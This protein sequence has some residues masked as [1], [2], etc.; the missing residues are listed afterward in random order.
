MAKKRKVVP[1]EGFDL[2]DIES[3]LQVAIPTNPLDRIIGQEEAV[4]IAKIAAT[5]RRHLLLVGPP[6]IGK[7]MTA[8]AL[9]FY[10]PLPENEVQVVHNPENP[11]RP[12]IEVKDREEVMRA[13]KQME[14][15]EGELI[16]PEIAPQEV[17][18]RLGFRCPAVAGSTAQRASTAPYANAPRYRSPDSPPRTPS[19]TS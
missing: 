12:F 7:S 15:A 3:T 2:Q 4:G 19:G 8:Q 5:Q 14:T 9:S 1:G 16:T 17:A 6:G 11:Q 18:E 13:I 10:L